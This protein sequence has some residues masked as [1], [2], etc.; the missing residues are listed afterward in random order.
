MLYS[1]CSE[2]GYVRACESLLVAQLSN[3]YRGLPMSWS[4]LRVEP[5]PT[6][7]GDEAE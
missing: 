2:C 4:T 7:A 1:F 6:S 3:M 5:D